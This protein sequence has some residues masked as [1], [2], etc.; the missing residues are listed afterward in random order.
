M[1][2]LDLSCSVTGDAAPLGTGETPGRAS[3]YSQDVTAR[4]NVTDDHA[5]VDP[6]AVVVAA[7]HV[8]A[9]AHVNHSTWHHNESM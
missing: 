8:R 9:S 6:S 3:V 1:T 5:L 4:Q 7:G 2:N